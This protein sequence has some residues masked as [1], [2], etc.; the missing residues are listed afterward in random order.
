MILEVVSN[1][2]VDNLRFNTSCLEHLGI[3]NAGQ[4]QNLGCLDGTARNND[5]ASDADCLRL[6]LVR[7][8]D[9]NSFIIVELDRC[10]GCL[11]Q[12]VKV[13]SLCVGSKV[14]SRGV[15]TFAFVGTCAD[16]RAKRVEASDVVARPSARM[17]I[18]LHQL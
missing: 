13:G 14:A 7:E 12:D 3:A 1:S 4:F 15:A 2:L 11:A 16:N 10:Y 18:K 5:F 6:G 8:V 9:T 17:S